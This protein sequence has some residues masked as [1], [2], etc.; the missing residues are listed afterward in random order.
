MSSQLIGTLAA[1]LLFAAACGVGRTGLPATPGEPSAWPSGDDWRAG[2]GGLFFDALPLVPDTQPAP[3][4]E[5]EEAVAVPEPPDDGFAVTQIKFEDIHLAQGNPRKINPNTPQLTEPDNLVRLSVEM[6]DGEA[7]TLDF[8]WAT[9]HGQF[10]DE[11]ATEVRFLASEEGMANI[12]CEFTNLA[13]GETGSRQI[14]INVQKAHQ[15]EV[16]LKGDY[17]VWSHIPNMIGAVHLPSR[18][19]INVGQGGLTSF[20][21]QRVT[22]KAIPLGAHAIDIFDLENPDAVVSIS[23]PTMKQAWDHRFI[24]IDGNRLYWGNANTQ[25]TAYKLYTMDLV[26]RIVNMPPVFSAAQART[27]NCS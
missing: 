18:K 21:G 19:L 23:T 17:A 7:E 13:T 27:G 3:D 1:L 15:S 25:Y 22:S 14:A 6:L 16:R 20:D 11:S 4:L 12:A 10:L 8:S 2:D 9:D 26:R 5:E 24:H